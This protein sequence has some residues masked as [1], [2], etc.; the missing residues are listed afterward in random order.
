MKTIKLQTMIFFL[1]MICFWTPSKVNAQDTK[2][3]KQE[4]KE[5][6]KAQLYAN[7]QAIDT[8][9][10]R[11][12]IVLEADFLRNQ[13]GDRVPVNSTINFIKIEPDNVVLQTG[14]NYGP[15]YNG[16]GGVT[17][18]GTINSWRLTKNLKHMNYNLRFSVSTNIGTYDVFMLIGAN[19]N[20]SATITGLTRGKLVYEGRVKALY[21]SSVFKGRKTY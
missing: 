18:E 11:R 8:L 20:A 3:T 19:N 12:S 9:L 17:A 6:R 7:F 21:N 10:N 15:G 14:N 4:K 13:Y 2:L 16:V 5:V 1:S